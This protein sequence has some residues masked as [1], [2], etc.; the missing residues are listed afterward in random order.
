MLYSKFI[1]SNCEWALFREIP[2]DEELVTIAYQ[3]T[4]PDMKHRLKAQ[5][6]IMFECSHKRAMLRYWE[7]CLQADVRL[8]ETPTEYQDLEEIPSDSGNK[9]TE[10][11]RIL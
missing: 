2:N 10:T 9:T 11:R 4:Y 6:C 1:C 3:C 5:Q 7:L 8:N